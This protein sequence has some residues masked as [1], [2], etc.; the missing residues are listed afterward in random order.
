M[1]L[2]WVSALRSHERGPAWQW[3]TASEIA[4]VNGSSCSSGL[5]PCSLLVPSPQRAG[6]VEPSLRWWWRCFPRSLMCSDTSCLG[7]FPNVR[8][9]HL[10]S[11]IHNLIHGSKGS[12]N[13]RCIQTESVLEFDPK[14]PAVWLFSPPTPTIPNF[15]I[16][17]FS[18]QPPWVSAFS[19]TSWVGCC[20]CYTAGLNLLHVT[21]FFSGCETLVD[22]RCPLRSWAELF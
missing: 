4:G 7:L 11:R 3:A 21:A 20:C 12:R 8:S 2:G 13:L 19:W 17:D 16:L 5:H 18:F 6:S 14:P 15:E 9:T 1:W 10:P 22:S